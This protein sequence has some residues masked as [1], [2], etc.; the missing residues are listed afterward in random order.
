MNWCELN[1]HSAKRCSGANEEIIYGPSSL[2]QLE[3]VIIKH[4]E[5]IAGE[6]LGQTIILVMLYYTEELLGYLENGTSDTDK[7]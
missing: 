1:Y 6:R 3:K 7:Q 4:L 5:H 2:F